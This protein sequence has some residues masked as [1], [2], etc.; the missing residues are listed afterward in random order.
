MVSEVSLEILISRLGSKHDK[1]HCCCCFLS[2]Q[3]KEKTL[4]A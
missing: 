4:N 2:G 3:V 1:D